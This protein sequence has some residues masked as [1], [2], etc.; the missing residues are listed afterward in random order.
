MS[1][2]IIR[3]LNLLK[4]GLVN[5]REEWVEKNRSLLFSQISNTLPEKDFSV[6]AKTSSFKQ[7]FLVISSAFDIKMFL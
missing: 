3:Q 6:H 4:N 2:Y 1:K 5:P 7:I